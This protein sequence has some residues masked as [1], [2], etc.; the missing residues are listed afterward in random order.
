MQNH[1]ST[2][3][4]DR[5][6]LTVTVVL[7]ANGAYLLSFASAD[8]F[9]V[10]NVLLHLVLGAAILLLWGRAVVR[11]VRDKPFSLLARLT[12]LLMLFSAVSGV[13][14]IVFG[15]LRPQR[16]IFWLHVA[17]S[18]GAAALFLHWLNDQAN[19]KPSVL[20]AAKLAV[21]LAPSF[22]L[23]V[24]LWDYFVP[25]EADRITNPA[26]P[27]ATMEGEAMQGAAGPFFPSSA[28]TAHGG[29]IP[30]KFFMNSESCARSGC[31]A[32]IYEQ[33]SSSAHRFSSFNNQWYRKS[34]EY[35]QSVAGV[36][37][38][39][40]CA[41]CHD[42]A[43]L[44][45]GQ[46]KQPVANFLESPEAEA[47]LGCVMCHSIVDVKGTMGNGGYILEFP[48]LNEIA[49]SENPIIRFLHDFSV[50]MNPKPHSRLFLKPFH[51]EQTAEFC[52][53]CHKAHL[54]KPVNNYRWVRGFN[55]YDNW[56]AS[57]VSGF[58]ARSFYYPPIPQKCT[59]CH[60]PL[61]PSDDAGNVDGFVHDHRFPGA[62][63]ALAVANQ[64][65]KQLQLQE[66]FLKGNQVSVDIFTVSKPALPSEAAASGSSS[67]ETPE[68]ASTFAVGEE[69][70]MA[71]GSGSLTR[72]AL[73][74]AGPL[75]DGSARLRPGDSVRLDVVVRTRGVGH[76]FPG[77][78]VDAQEVWLELK[79]EDETGRTIFW[80]G[81]IAD[82]GNGPVDPSAH[83]YKSV[84]LDG[85]G[86]LINKRNAWAARSVLYV[87]LIPPGAADVA[88]YRLKIP[89]DCGEK[90]K[91]TAKLHYR[92]FNWWNNNWAYA[93]ER[94]PAAPDFALSPHYDDGNWVFTG[95][96]RS[97]SGK[98]KEI[99]VLPVVTM[100]QDSVTLAVGATKGKAVVET[101]GSPVTRE[102]WN[103]YG[104]ALL[105]EGDLKGAQNAFQEVVRIEPDYADGW[106]NLARAYLLEGDVPN[107]RLALDSSEEVAPG[108]H[109]AAFF[110]GILFKTSGE[111]DAALE[112]LNKVLVDYPED[113]VVLNQIG[114]V[115][116]LNSYPQKAVPFFE[117]ALAIDAEDL[118]AH[119]NLMLCYRALGQPDAAKAHEVLYQR[120]KADEKAAAIAQDYR[121][122]HPHDNNEAQPIHEHG[123]GTELARDIYKSYF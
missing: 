28:G 66:S 82:S 107:A 49:T 105:R 95:D 11:I 53:A 1:K 57:G 40:W 74:I 43:L 112:H 77:G 100:A 25:N 64:D 33:W 121:R 97:V 122:T 92:K 60:M 4:F 46:M 55:E 84:L 5:W 10:T 71:V 89:D 26:M 102:R 98:L 7:L 2:S 29:K 51:R 117:Q 17:G 101:E 27:P 3:G 54:D 111:Y 72:E 38:P 90:L 21:I 96:T 68:T 80:S 70:G 88:H 75:R 16:V 6:S 85:H 36:E 78:T 45:S 41:G 120:Y 56:Q 99:P 13:Y 113:R 104:I 35:M 30:S 47:G 61:L 83:F 32:D 93:G 108:F 91:V 44:F 123:S 86:N 110:L 62:N 20:R 42:P 115:H 109:K 73:A 39:Q 50:K 114:R 118:M 34:I 59:D 14:L 9:Y 15:N 76:F 18:F 24:T 79:A 8:L 12:V 65:D 31:H 52:S 81:A 48:E 106:V 58:G 63:T 103:D 94:D 37:A 116:Y 69:Q 22:V 119:Y 87:N 67:T 19:L 23:S